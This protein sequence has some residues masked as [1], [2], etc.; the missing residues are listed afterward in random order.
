MPH[1][2][3]GGDEGADRVA[4]PVAVPEDMLGVAQSYAALAAREPDVVGVLGYLWPGGLEGP[5]QLGARE[6]PGD[7]RAFYE[8]WGAAVV[9]PP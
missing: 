2:P 4:G 5:E 8:R 1:R 6:L 3:A 7:V 9:A